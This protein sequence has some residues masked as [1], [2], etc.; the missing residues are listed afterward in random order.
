MPRKHTLLA[1]RRFQVWRVRELTELGV[2]LE[3]E[4][5][6]SSRVSKLFVGW[7]QVRGLLKGWLLPR[8][9][10]YDPAQGRLRHLTIRFHNEE[11]ARVLEFYE[12]SLGLEVLRSGAVAGVSNGTSH[13]RI[14]LS[15]LCGGL[16][17]LSVTFFVMWLDASAD[18]RTLLAWSGLSALAAGASVAIWQTALHTRFQRKFRHWTLDQS[19]LSG[20]GGIKMSLAHACSL[21]SEGLRLGWAM[22]V[23]WSWFG[24][25]PGLAVIMSH[26]RDLG[27][28][29]GQDGEIIDGP[30]HGCDGSSQ[31]DQAEVCL[32]A[33]KRLLCGPGGVSVPHIPL[34]GREMENG[35]L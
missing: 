2:T 33:A 23:P 31:N 21:G 13:L 19:G 5:N 17:L 14:H 3:S 16:G 34:S 30:G 27:A 8:M 22:T 35:K 4:A 26:C 25:G 20:H 7:P 29:Q 18:G 11:P 10:W 15:R 32:L 28:S 9:V 12:R 24:R 1:N 6:T